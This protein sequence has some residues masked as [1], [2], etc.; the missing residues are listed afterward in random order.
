MI[1][2][3][4]KI[5]LP[6]WMRCDKTQK[7]MQVIGGDQT[8]PQSLVVGGCVRNELL[9]VPVSDI[10]I[11]TQLTPD[12]VMEKLKAAGIKAVPTGIDHGT[13]TAI[14]DR[15]PFEITS[16]RQDVSTDGRHADVEF[17]DDWTQDARRRDFTMNTLLADLS[18]NIY[19]PTRQGL[20]NLRARNVIFV[21]DAATRIAEDYLRIL[22]FFRFHAVYG[23]GEMDAGALKACAAAADKISSL[24][25]E[26]IT[27]EFLK[28]LAVSGAPEILKIM[29]NHKVL[30]GLA[31]KSYQVN[32]LQRLCD[33]QEKYSPSLSYFGST[34]GSKTISRDPAIK[35]QDDRVGVSQDDA[36]GV[37]ALMARLFVLAG[38]KP[39]LFDDYLRLSH[40]QTK[41]LIKLEMAVSAVFYGDEKALKKAIFYHGNDLMLQG[42]L[43]VLAN[44]KTQENKE[45]IGVLQNWQAPECPITGETLLA[46]GYQT[47]PELGLEL[48]RRQEEWLEGVI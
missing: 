24:S 25:R 9:G 37:N 42:Y 2:P 16:L 46:E 40:A 12:Q 38:Y 27:Q 13:V 20:T 34:E 15:K 11:A 22:R 1:D 33:L 19:D 26:R 4:Q 7:L 45:M 23:Q 30:T 28:I 6:E 41:F 44:G 8:P 48:K 39:S 18:G 31:D 36:R 10:D 35:S 17:T 32:M 3:V 5:E 43:L 21:G 29:F 14:V 47:G